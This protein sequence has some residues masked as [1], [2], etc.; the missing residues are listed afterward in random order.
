MEPS[1]EESAGDLILIALCGCSRST[2]QPERETESAKSRPEVTLKVL[3]LEGLDNLI[4]GHKGKIV[5]MDCW[6][7]W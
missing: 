7:T 4:A 5:V 1:L 2:P 6:S 3:D